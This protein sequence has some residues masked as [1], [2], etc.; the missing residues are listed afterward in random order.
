MANRADPDQLASEISWLLKKPTDLDLHCLQRQD[1]SGFSR[2]R[3]VMPHPLLC[4][5]QSDSLIQVIAINSQSEWQTG[6]I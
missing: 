3:F 2:K 4:V 6:Q 5:S 1:I